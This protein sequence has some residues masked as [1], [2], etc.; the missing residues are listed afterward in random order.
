MFSLYERHEV[1]RMRNEDDLYTKLSTS[2]AP[3]VHGH[4]D[5]KKGVLL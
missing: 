4:M 1:M 2:I 3:S 5:V